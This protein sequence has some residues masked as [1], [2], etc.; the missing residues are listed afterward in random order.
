MSDEPVKTEPS[1]HYSPL[2]MLNFLGALLNEVDCAGRSIDF[3]THKA[4][5]AEEVELHYNHGMTHL[6]DL[7]E[8][9]SFLFQFFNSQNEIEF[10]NMDKSQQIAVFKEMIEDEVFTKALNLMK[11]KVIDKTPEE[12]V[13]ELFGTTNI[14]AVDPDND[15]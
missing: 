11:V 3:A 13:N 14:D 15:L 2:K 4:E 8:G 6:I 1:S 10:L 7:R 5:G 9:L 12:R